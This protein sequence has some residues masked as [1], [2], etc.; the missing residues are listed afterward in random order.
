MAAAWGALAAIRLTPAVVLNP[1]AALG[2]AFGFPSEMTATP[3]R[4]GYVA[5]WSTRNQGAYIALLDQ[6]GVAQ[7][8][9]RIE[10]EGLEAHQVSASDGVDALIAFRTYEPRSLGIVVV[11]VKADG[12]IT[13]LP[14]QPFAPQSLRWNGT[15]YIAVTVDRVIELDR[16]GTVIAETSIPAPAHWDR[17]V[18]YAEGPRVW[19]VRKNGTVI[20]RL[21]LTDDAGHVISSEWVRLP[22]AAGEWDFLV[23]AGAD[24]SGLFLLTQETYGANPAV[25]FLDRDGVPNA[26]PVVLEGFGALSDVRTGLAGDGSLLILDLQRGQ[27]ARLARGLGSDTPVRGDFELLIGRRVRERMNVTVATLPG[28]R[29]SSGDLFP[30]VGGAL[31]IGMAKVYQD[32]EWTTPV[33]TY[34][35]A[36][37]NGVAIARNESLVSATPDMRRAAAAPHGDGFLVAWQQSALAGPEIWIRSVDA[38][39]QPQGPAR[40]LGA[41]AA[42]QVASRGDL[43]M[44]VWTRPEN[45]LVIEARRIGPDGS[46]IDSAPVTL[47]TSP[48]PVTKI[49]FDAMQFN[50]FYG[51]SSYGPTLPFRAAVVPAEDDLDVKPSV[52][53][54][55]PLP[56][57]N[58]IGSAPGHTLFANL[59][60]TI[61]AFTLRHDLSPYAPRRTISILRGFTGGAFWNGQQFELAWWHIDHLRVSR[62]STSG[63][64]IDSEYGQFLSTLPIAEPT[65]PEFAMVLRGNQYVIATTRQLAVVTPGSPAESVP[66]AV[67]RVEALVVR[68]DRTTLLV[69]SDVVASS[70]DHKKSSLSVR[71]MFW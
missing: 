18:V 59:G 51:T 26:E 28:F 20:E 61:D 52:S 38:F 64:P 15:S 62:I 45:G 6:Q 56:H 53:A 4:G 25:Q 35:R 32:G 47:T 19:M 10:I 31:F 37:H 65:A 58:L 55:V 21:A 50:I 54:V 9:T 27:V 71:K 66:L 46:P 60:S 69:T 30:A 29:R 57:P 34:I 33:A 2:P 12:S 68:P 49:V 40:F 44:V 16:D 5:A 17:P 42:P 39:G 11:R 8:V 14:R 70:G 43:A 63:E 48:S 1:D 23:A 13:Q 22:F 41:G 3:V 67:R 36:R 24:R 7:G